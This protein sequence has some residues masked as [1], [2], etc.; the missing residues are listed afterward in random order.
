MVKAGH[1][2]LYLVVIPLLEIPTVIL[3]VE[4]CVSYTVRVYNQQFSYNELYSDLHNLLALEAVLAHLTSAGLLQ[5]VYPLLVRLS[6]DHEGRDS[7]QTGDLL[8]KRDE[9]TPDC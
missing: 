7:V 9:E 8:N 4:L 1:C 2:Q 6:N 3:L 5:Q